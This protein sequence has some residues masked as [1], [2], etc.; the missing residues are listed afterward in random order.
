MPP[1]TRY[2]QKGGTSIAYQV[3]GDGPV[4][5]VLVN[6]IVS[7]MSLLWGDPAASAFFRRLTSFSRLVLFDKPGTGLSDPVAGPPSLEQRLED[8][9]VVMDAAGLEHAAI[10][11]YSE[12]GPPAALFAATYPRRCDALVLAEAGAKFVADDDYLPESRAKLD[13]VWRAAPATGRRWGAQSGSARVPEWREPSC[14]RP[15]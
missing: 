6:G 10:L 14:V 4:D 15:H 9:R 11:G 13:Q 3:V 8:I 12:G 7:H 5:L 1:E 2:A